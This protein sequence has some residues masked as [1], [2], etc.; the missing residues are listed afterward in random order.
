MTRDEAKKILI[1]Y[2]SDRPDA[3]DPEFSEALRLAAS[4]SELRQWF[5]MQQEFHSAIRTQ[6]KAIQAP[7]DLKGRIL[8]EKPA[9]ESK[10]IQF[11]REMLAIAAAIALLFVITT[12]LWLK[13]PHDERSFANFRSRMTSFALRTYKMDIL[14]TDGA[15]VRKHLSIH[16]AP[17]DFSLPP[18]IASLP[19]KGGGRLSWQNQPVAMICF[20]LP[21]HQTLFMFVADEKSIPDVASVDK[22]QTDLRKGLPS[23]AWHQNDRVYLI[24]ANTDASTLLK[25]APP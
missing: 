17:S 16:G 19:I 22:V 13:T 6:L 7:A 3:N 1:R 25:L 20:E 9:A 4:D 15:A 5:G 10:I 24:A 23:A 12:A 2:R 14:T 18:A 21:T 8:A 11:P